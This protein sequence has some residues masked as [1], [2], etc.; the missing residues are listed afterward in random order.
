M[1][2]AN[3]AEVLPTA[4]TERT[5]KRA[6]AAGDLAAAIASCSSRATIAFGVWAGASRPCHP[7]MW[8][9][10]KVSA[11][12]GRSGASRSRVAVARMRIL[13]VC[14]SGCSSAK[15]PT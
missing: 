6:T 1:L 8:K 13:P 2:A 9:P 4:L 5:F 14:T 3:S 10:G 7:A 11:T 12:V 15:L